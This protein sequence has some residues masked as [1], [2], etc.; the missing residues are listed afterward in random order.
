LAKEVKVIYYIGTSFKV[1]IDY[2]SP[3]LFKKV[4]QKL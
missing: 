1:Q 3:Q 4:E 2:G